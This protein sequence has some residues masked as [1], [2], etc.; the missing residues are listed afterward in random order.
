MFLKPHLFLANLKFETTDDK[1]K[2][3][4]SP[5]GEIVGIYIKP[6]NSWGLVRM[7]N[8]EDAWKA[9]EELQGK[10]FKGIVLQIRKARAAQDKTQQQET[11]NNAEQDQKTEKVHENG[12]SL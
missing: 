1:I 9:M 10:E 7:L 2:D 11:E 12:E 5:F 4:L 3:L 8:E 6:G